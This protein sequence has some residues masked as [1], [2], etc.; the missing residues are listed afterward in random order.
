MERSIRLFL[1]SFCLFV[2]IIATS[3][4]ELTE[5]QPF[6]ELAQKLKLKAP[7]L[8]EGEYEIRVWNR[9]ALMYGDAQSL[10][11]L[12]K[13]KKAFKV[14]RYI[15]AWDGPKFS[16]ATKFN[17]TV[18]ITDS[19]WKKLVEEGLLSW[20][21]ETIIEQ[22]LHPKQP[23]DSTRTSVEPDGSV[24]VIARKRK[25]SVWISDGEGYY[26]DVISHDL[27]Q[28]Y[29]YGNPRAYYQARPDIHELR[30]VVTILNSISGLFRTVR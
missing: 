22:Q 19:L 27:H 7:K 18:S 13:R 12:S 23:P 10:Y 1:C 11:V 20:P 14:E 16:Y 8:T 21:D 29:R 30:K 6:E 2:S 25:P 17:P 9:Q 26:I 24:S 15:I 3:Q 5:K 4:N 28:R